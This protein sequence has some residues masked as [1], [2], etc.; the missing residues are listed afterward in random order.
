MHLWPDMEICLRGNKH[1]PM[2]K[3]RT[4]SVILSDH[5]N[6][7]LLSIVNWRPRA[8][9]AILSV[10][11]PP[12]AVYLISNSLR[13]STPR[14]D[15]PLATSS[16]SA[17]KQAEFSV[18]CNTTRLQ[19][20]HCW[21]FTTPSA[22]NVQCQINAT[23]QKGNNRYDNKI[24][25]SRQ[26]CFCNSE[27]ESFNLAMWSSAALLTPSLQSSQWGGMHLVRVNDLQSWDWSWM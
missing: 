15:K 25:W 19:I 9:L 16:I 11:L 2:L 20:F 27:N 10:W 21:E 14:Y 23:K 7:Q 26:I 8:S 6:H 12:I 17:C 18:H 22:R 1:N 3:R 4:V 13:S 24:E 5:K